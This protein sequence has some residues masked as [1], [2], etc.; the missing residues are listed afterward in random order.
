LGEA[1]KK[2]EAAPAVEAKPDDKAAAPAADAPVEAKAEPIVYDFKIP[3]GVA[4]ADGERAELVDL[5]NEG[6]AQPEYAQKLLDRHYAEVK[7]VAESIRAEQFSEWNKTQD[8]WRG[9]VMA[10]PELGGPRLQTTLNMAGTVLEQ[11]GS[12]DL[13]KMLGYTGAGNHPAMV[14]FMHNIA[15]A[16]GEGRPVPA[17]P[18]VSQAIKTRA[19]R[20]YGTK[21]NGAA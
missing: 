10:D 7:K 14:R 9:Q 15:R 5:F 13:R 4:L 6:K 1:G 3:E 18:P 19:D 17:P 20:L 21:P 8:E 2:P 16:L 11:Y 12:D